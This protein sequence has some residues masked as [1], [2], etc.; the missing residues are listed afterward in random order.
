MACAALHALCHIAAGAFLV[1]YLIMYLLGGLPLFYLELA[2]GQYQRVGCISVWKRICPL[3]KGESSSVYADSLFL[4]QSAVSQL[5]T[6][7]WPVYTNCPMGS[8][9]VSS[10]V[11]P[12]TYLSSISNPH[13]SLYDATLWN[14]PYEKLIL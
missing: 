1:P 11:Y 12:I 8:G 4:L 14:I 2:L 9:S 7:H 13:R 10:T 3:L 5:V 6:S